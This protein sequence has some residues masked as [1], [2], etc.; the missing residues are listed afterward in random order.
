MWCPAA[1]CACSGSSHA[2]LRISL[3]RPLPPCLPAPQ[4]LSTYQ[5]QLEAKQKEVLDFQAKYN[6]RIKV[7][8]GRGL[9]GH[10][11]GPWG[12]G[13]EGGQVRW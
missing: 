12:R 8:A 10:S 7:R 13:Q 6:I 1:A 2:S 11:A 9:G 4:L 5:R 3:H